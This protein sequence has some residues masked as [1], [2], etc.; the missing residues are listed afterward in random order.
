MPQSAISTGSVDFVLPVAK[1]PA[2]LIDFRQ[3][4]NELGASEVAMP[5]K[6]GGDCL[7]E[8]IEL[9]RNK[10]AHDFT[11]YKSGTLHRRIE[12]RMGLSKVALNSMERYLQILQ[13]NPGRT[14]SSVQRSP[15]QCHQFFPRSEGF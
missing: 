10:T 4:L 12:R 15:D 7:T 14:R 3:R 5:D 9:L 13:E 1:I 2:A 8:I 11:L 6:N